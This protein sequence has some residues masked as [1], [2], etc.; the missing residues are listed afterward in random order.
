MNATEK[1]IEFAN[2]IKAKFIDSVRSFIDSE[3]DLEMLNA[4]LN[5]L[6]VSEKNAIF[7]IDLFKNID[8]N[9]TSDIAVNGLNGWWLYKSKSAVHGAKL[10]SLIS[11]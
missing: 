11:K 8:M 7:W 2:T 9:V 1:Q 4:F 5:S 10:S 6:H 3:C